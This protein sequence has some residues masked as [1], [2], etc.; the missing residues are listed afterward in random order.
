M[1]DMNDKK[2]KQMANDENEKDLNDY[3]TSPIV[4]VIIY[5]TVSIIL[6]LKKF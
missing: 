4:V 1:F 2:D 5:S 6:L 3:W